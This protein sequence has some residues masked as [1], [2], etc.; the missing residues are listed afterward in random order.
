MTELLE[1]FKSFERILEGGSFMSA[2]IIFSVMTFFK[3]L[4][5]F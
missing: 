1:I 5:R 4:Y 3:A 2:G